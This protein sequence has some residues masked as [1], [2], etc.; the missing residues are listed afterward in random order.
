M[1]AVPQRNKI[2]KINGKEAIIFYRSSKSN[3]KDEPNI[4]TI[5]TLK[6]VNE[7]LKGSENDFKHDEGITTL[8]TFNDWDEQRLGVNRIAN[9][10]LELRKIIPHGWLITFKHIGDRKNKYGLEKK[11]SAI[12]FLENLKARIEAELK[13]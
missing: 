9:H 11:K 5:D 7:L 6:V 12:K 8:S 2:V 1:S 3:Q 4:Y 13:S 10:I